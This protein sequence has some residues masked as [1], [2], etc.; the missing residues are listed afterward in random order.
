[1]AHIRSF[2]YMPFRMWVRRLHNELEL[3]PPR[4]GPHVRLSPRLAEQVLS[5]APAAPRGWADRRSLAA[6]GAGA[7]DRASLLAERA[8]SRRLRDQ[9][10]RRMGPLLRDRRAG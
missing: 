2:P 10:G 7:R 5:A 4:T 9:D 6:G 1:S 8:G 3:D